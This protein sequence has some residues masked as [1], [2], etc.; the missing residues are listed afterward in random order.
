MCSLSH[1]NPYFLEIRNARSPANKLLT[2]VYQ[3]QTA[4]QAYLS[5]HLKIG[6]CTISCSTL[7]IKAGANKEQIATTAITKM[8][9]I[10][11]ES[12]PGK[13]EGS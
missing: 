3:K 10:N 4:P 13:K 12:L 5:L 6:Y 8:E 11:K 1:E 2:L 9:E 7:G